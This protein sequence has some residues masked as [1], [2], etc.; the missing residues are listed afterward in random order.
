MG[1]ERT[2]NLNHLISGEGAFVF[3]RKSPEGYIHLFI[4][5]F[6]FKALLSFVHLSVRLSMSITLR[7]KNVKDF[8]NKNKKQYFEKVNSVIYNAFYILT[9]I[10]GK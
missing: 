1:T 7:T 8:L 4:F 6:I 2:D 9:Y 5:I 3:V 10:F